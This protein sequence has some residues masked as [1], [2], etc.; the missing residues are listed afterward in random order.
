MNQHDK[1]KQLLKSLTAVMTLAMVTLAVSDAFADDNS[2]NDFVAVTA[3]SIK[4]DPTLAKILENIEKS[5]EDLANTQQRTEQERLLDEQRDTANNILEQELAQMFKDNEEFTSASAFGNFLKKISDNNTKTVFQGLFEYQQNKVNAAR[6][7]MH[8]VLR[9]GGS[10]QD[11]RDAYHEAAKIPRSDMI[12]L[13]TTMNINAGFS[14]PEIQNNFDD[15]GKLPR[16]DDEQESVLSFVDLTSYPKNVNTSTNSTADPTSQPLDETDV[17][18]NTT[19]QN[20]STSTQD[21]IQKLLDE[22]QSLKNKIK[23]LENHDATI[24]KAVLE[25]QNSDSIKYADWVSDYLQGLGNNGHLIKDEKSIPVNALNAPNSYSDER[26]SLTLGRQ[27]Q[28]TLG[29][30][31]PV[32]DKLIVYEASSQKYIN[33][34][35]T[36]EVSADGENWTKLT[37]TQYQSDGSYVHEYAYDLSDVGCITHVRI[38]DNATSNWGDGFDVDA[39]GATKTCIDSP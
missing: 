28:V 5:K 37:Q 8:N 14:D 10:L 17:Q 36:V 9:N 7:A 1:A 22:I 23:E 25:T 3:D 18:N 16:Y 4:N 13:V 31:E 32:T 11:A 39:V 6:D 35:A 30:S 26:N 12:Q 34:I 2:E 24:Q 29:F 15:D 20:D 38:T 27:G 21:V 19:T 33:E